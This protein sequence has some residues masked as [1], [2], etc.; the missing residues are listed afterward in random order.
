MTVGMFTGPHPLG[1][2]A[3]FHLIHLMPIVF[4]SVHIDKINA[5]QLQVV[6]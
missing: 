6:L 1:T 3:V 2:F 4:L 5:G